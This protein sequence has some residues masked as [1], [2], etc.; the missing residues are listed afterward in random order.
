MSKMVLVCPRERAQ[1]RFTKRDIEVLAERIMPDNI[2]PAPPL[3][4][5]EKGLLIGIFNPQEC[6]LRKETSICLGALLQK[7][8]L[9]WE[10]F[11]V[12]PDGSY[13]LFRTNENTIELVSDTVAS[14]TVWYIQTEELFVAATSQR[15]IVFF[16]Q[17]FDCNRAVFSWMLSSGSL[18]L[19]MSW[20]TRLRCLRGGERLILNRSSWLLTVDKKRLNFNSTKE[21]LPEKQEEELVAALG[22]AFENL[23]LVWSKWILPLSGGYDSRAI[24]LM[25]KHYCDLQCVT[26]GL[27]ESLGEIGS[28]AYIAKKLAQHFN[29]RHTYYET[30]ISEEP[31]DRILKRFLIAGEGRIDHFGGYSDGFGI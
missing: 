14:R 9:W 24:L 23:Q 2:T 15:A 26:W 8:E 31:A 21:Q 6:I 7:D 28:D 25:L 30:D 13:A 16:L 20:D 19:G 5:E 29:L 10:P 27:K 17:S 12:I 1:T 11:A 22:R 3:V 4:I 18:G